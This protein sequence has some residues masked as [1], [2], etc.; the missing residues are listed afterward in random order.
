MVPVDLDTIRRLLPHRYPFLLIDRVLELYSGERIR[1]L[2]NV[3]SNEEFFNGHFPGRPIMPGV[4][5]LEAM[6]QACG[7]LASEC[8]EAG[9]EQGTILVF[10]G[11]DK[12]R[13]RRAVVPGDQLI[14]DCTLVKRKREIWKFAAEARVDGELVA[15][16]DMMCASQQVDRMRK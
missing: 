2:K 14:F 11:I 6:A 8:A 3:T 16:A 4:L 10:A 9:P 12:A 1:A 5:I 7:L 15:A 13:F